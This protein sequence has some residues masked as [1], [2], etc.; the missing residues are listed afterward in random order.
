MRSFEV[1]KELGRGTVVGASFGTTFGWRKPL[2]QSPQFWAEVPTV[3]ATVWAQLAHS[4]GAGGWPQ[5]RHSFSIVSPQFFHNSTTV[6][7]SS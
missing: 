1:R 2:H 7:P 3:R 4:W 5:F 6:A